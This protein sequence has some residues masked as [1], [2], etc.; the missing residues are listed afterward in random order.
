MYNVYN[1][2]APFYLQDL[3]LHDLNALQL[4]IYEYTKY[5]IICKSQGVL[6][7][8]LHIKPARHF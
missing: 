2:T 1:E 3:D 4:C 8:F 7:L 6:F 5:D